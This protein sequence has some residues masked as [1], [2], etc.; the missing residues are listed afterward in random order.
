MESSLPQNTEERSRFCY[1][2]I[3]GRLQ[4]RV[5]RKHTEAKGIFFGGKFVPFVMSAGGTL[6]PTADDYLKR[7][8]VADPN[9]VTQFI[10]EASAALAKSRNTAYLSAFI[11]RAPAPDTEQASSSLL[12]SD[13]V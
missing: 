3:R 1:Q 5:D 10:F 9:L 6:H 13:V 7:L 12:S 2:I 11:H 4:G 8:R